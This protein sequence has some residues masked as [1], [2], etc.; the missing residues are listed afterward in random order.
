MTNPEVFN[1]PNGSKMHGH[2]FIQA[3]HP[4]E[5]RQLLKRLKE[6]IEHAERI[7]GVSAADLPELTEDDHDR[8]AL[9][10]INHWRTR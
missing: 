9:E 4:D 2:E 6:S 10:R 1:D 8:L 3:D 5:I 7:L